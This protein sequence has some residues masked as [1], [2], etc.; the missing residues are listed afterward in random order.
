MKR[1]EAIAP[2]SREHHQALILAQLLKTNAPD[3]KGLP[4]TIVGKIEY[5]KNF[6]AEHLISHFKKEEEV[7][8]LILVKHPTFSI[9]VKEINDEHQSL[10]EKFNQLD[11]EISDAASLHQIGI[12]L[13]QHIRKEERQLF[14]LIESICSPEELAAFHDYLHE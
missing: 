9:W 1:H 4:S 8:S 11:T 5:A 10:A 12:L 3:Y 7:L 14:P 13:E 6:Y 2:L